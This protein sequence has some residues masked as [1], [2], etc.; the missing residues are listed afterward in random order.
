[1]KKNAFTLLELLIVISIIAILVSLALPHLSSALLKGEML[2][3]LSN[4]RQLYLATQAMAIDANTSGTPN[5]GWP[6]DMASPSFEA[7]ASALCHGY[8]SV[9]DFC[10]LCSAPGV[11]LPVDKIPSTAHE[12]ALTLYPL[13][14]SSDANDIFLITRNA[15]LQGSGTNLSIGF[16]AKTKPYGNKGC[17]L[18]RRGGDAVS[19]LPNQATNNPRALGSLGASAATPLQ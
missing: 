1:M 16:D 3:T 14:E 17:V 11:V 7:W 4:E 10:K 6:G 15:T 9:S 13:Q 2:Q 12:I 19:L 18:I 5:L 8:L